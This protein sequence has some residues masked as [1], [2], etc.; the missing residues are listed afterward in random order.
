MTS[1][2]NDF[3]D[4]RRFR[5]VAEDW[6]TK[7]V[8]LGLTLVPMKLIT[9]LP[10]G[11]RI[12]VTDMEPVPMGDVFAHRQ[13]TYTYDGGATRPA[14]EIVFEVRNGVPVCTGISLRS[15]DGGTHV[16]AKD[17]T[18]IK[19]D[20]LRDDVFAYVGVF[21][22]NPGGGLVRKLG[23]GSLR[24]DRKRIERAT[25]RRKITPEFLNR[26]AEIHNG[27]PEGGRVAA[28]KAAFKVK[29]RQ[30]LRYIKLARQKGLTN[31]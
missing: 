19:L 3:S 11:G 31:G 26:V 29:E 7:A 28:V 24:E 22:P 8:K 14:C 1:V 6:R 12:E 25:Q 16:R 20:N 13:L 23:P 15:T 17:L 10:D 21:V 5:T 18:G 4:D 2:L 27:A 9:E 30:A